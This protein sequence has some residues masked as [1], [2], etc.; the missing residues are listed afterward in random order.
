MRKA[1]S[2]RPHNRD[3][4]WY[5]IRRVPKEFADLDRRGIVRLSTGIAVADD[6]RAIRAGKVVL[7]LG[8]ELEAYWRG[9]RDGQS[10]EAQR[11]FEAAQQRAR[12]LGLPYRTAE[13]L[14][15]S[16]TLDEILKR[17][18][19]LSDMGAIQKETEVA[20]ILGGEKRPEMQLSDLLKE[21]EAL[22]SAKL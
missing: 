19:L 1:G 3:G 5:L 14:Q 7:T 22:Q 15:E 16:A 9:L 12:K 21:F 6:P 10:G 11:R 18:R 4:V 20:A 13:E 17:V 8:A 2:A